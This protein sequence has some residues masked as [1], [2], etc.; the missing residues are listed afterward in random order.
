[1]IRLS[2]ISHSPFTQLFRHHPGWLGLRR[3]TD[4]GLVSGIPESSEQIGACFTIFDPS[5]LC[6]KASRIRV[7]PRSDSDTRR[8]RWLVVPSFW[9]AVPRERLTEPTSREYGC[10]LG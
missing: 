5:A 10:P 8:T 7:L 9:G 2:V 6:F 4:I 3:R 1:M